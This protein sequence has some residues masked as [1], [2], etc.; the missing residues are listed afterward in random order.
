MCQCVKCLSGHPRSGLSPRCSSCPNQASPRPSGCRETPRAE[1]GGAAPA[2]KP[3]LVPG[4]GRGP[5]VTRGRG[6][7][8]RERERRSGAGRERAGPGDLP[9]GLRRGSEPHA[10]GAPR[11]RRRHQ[12]AICSGDPDADTNAPE[13]AAAATAV[14][15]ATTARS[16]GS[17]PVGGRALQ[18]AAARHPIASFLRR[19]HAPGVS[20]NPDP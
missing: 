17:K 20:T 19:V 5:G 15:A 11:R 3:R 6:V 12:R 4:R 16:L 8:A 7:G 10:S 1:V 18:K 14:R 9:G 2:C 13:A